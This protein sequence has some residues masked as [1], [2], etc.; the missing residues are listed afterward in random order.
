MQ[1]NFGELQSPQPLLP[2]SGLLSLFYAFNE[3]G[4]IF[5][6]DDGYIVA[7]YWKD[8][9]GFIPFNRQH[10]EPIAIK[11]VNRIDLP[12]NEDLRD[13]WPFDDEVLAILTEEL[14]EMIDASDEYLLGYPS[15]YTLAYDPTPDK[16][17]A[18]LLTLRSIDALDWCWQDGNKLMV[19]VKE[20][21]L[22][23]RDFSCLKCDAG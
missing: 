12:R 22:A 19:F 8:W 20:E 4:D 15:F 9:E 11:M 10:C 23:N 6:G 14:P 21:K 17:W 1:I 2:E 3:N 16:G 5:W 13:D 7:F 18:S